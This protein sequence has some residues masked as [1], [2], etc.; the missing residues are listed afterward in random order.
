MV[1]GD[2]LRQEGVLALRQ[3]DERTD[4]VDVGVDLDVQNVVLS[5]EAHEE[6]PSELVSGEDAG[7]GRRA[8]VIRSGEGVVGQRQCDVLQLQ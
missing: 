6:R 1:L 8:A 2:D 5:C 3:L 4:A 7:A